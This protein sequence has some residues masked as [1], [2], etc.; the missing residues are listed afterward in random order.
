MSPDMLSPIASA[1]LRAAM[2]SVP[3]ITDDTVTFWPEDGSV[4][5]WADL[6]VQDR[7]MVEWDREREM[8]IGHYGY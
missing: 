3:P 8:Y 7:K 5:S 6:A 1:M 2:R 4:S